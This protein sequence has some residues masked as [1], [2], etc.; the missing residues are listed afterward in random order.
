MNCDPPTKRWTTWLGLALAGT[1]LLRLASLD[2][3]ALTDNTE[4]RYASIAWQMFSSGDWVTPRIY[5]KGAL[6]PFWGKPPL[7]FWLTSLSYHIFGVSEWSTRM[8]SFLLGLAIVAATMYF[9]DQ[10]WGRRVALLSGVV[11]ATSGLFFILSGACVLDVPLAAS[12]AGAMIAFARFADSGPRRRWWGLAFF[13]ALAAGALAKG[14]IALVLVGAAL[15]L[16]LLA[17]G[18]W[19]LVIQLPWIGGLVVFFAVAAPWYLLAERATPGFLHYFIVHEHFL[20]YVSHEYGDLYGSG[21]KQPFGASW[22]FLFASFLPWSLLTLAALV[23]RFRGQKVFATLRNDPWLTYALAWGL[24][25]PL[26]FTLARQIL[27]TYL[28]PGFAGLAVAA[29]VALDRWIES[30]AAP[31]LGRWLKWHIAAI[32]L[33]TVVGAI[34]AVANGDP[35]A[36]AVALPVATACV[37]GLAWP[38]LRRGTPAAL[39]GVLGLATSTALCATLFLI[40]PTVN[41]EHSAKLILAE[42][43]RNPGAKDRPIVAPMTGDCS[44]LFYSQAF[45]GGRF[46]YPEKEGSH[47]VWERLDRHGRE[48]FLFPRSDFARLKPDLAARLQSLAET[49]HWV[50]CEEKPR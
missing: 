48:I 21:R 47:V 42:V 17:V 45:F 24:A 46:T 12:V 36:L 4:S 1:A 40:A 29:A 39:V 23:R 20:R 50:A 16:W 19:R 25:P 43:Y 37:V 11:L 9:A 35:I 32:G 8:P 18:R 2:R 28:V 27:V 38:V 6:V 26:F 49:L 10:V 41:D 34:A 22:A 15:G 7:E 33:A 44:P 5:T 30:D 3:L 14:P 13:L 31:A